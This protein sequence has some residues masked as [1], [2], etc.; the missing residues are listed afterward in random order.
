MRNATST[1][2]KKGKKDKDE[3][4]ATFPHIDRDKFV[5]LPLELPNVDDE[6]DESY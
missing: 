2:K 3:L 1:K 6:R 4:V 5:L